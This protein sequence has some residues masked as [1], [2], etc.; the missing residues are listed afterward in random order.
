MSN[1]IDIKFKELREAGQ[2]AL[3]SFLT[4][5]F[6]DVKTSQELAQAILESGSDMLEL[7]IPFSDP[8]ADGRTI[9]KTNLHALEQ[10][11]NIATSLNM[12]RSLRSKGVA[13]PVIFMGYYN[14]FLRYGLNKFA[15][16]ASAAGLDGIIVPDLPSEEALP[17]KQAC[18]KGNIH[19]IPLLAPTSTDQRIA[20]ACEQA[21]GF[22]Y[23]VSLT[24][25]TGARKQL[26][27]GLE[28][29]VGRI[30]HHTDLPIAVGF[31]VSNP[32]HVDTISQFADGVIFASALLDTIDKSPRDQV[33][34]EATNFVS[35][36][37][38]ST[39]SRS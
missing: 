36:L 19:L 1:R 4:T 15:Q 3:I 14:P 13:S 18:N 27:P 34:Q 24:G 10:G 33:L 28:E 6:P 26:A 38:T 2:I 5:G 39:R 11:V 16:D 37:R 29:F 7:G 21:N 20:K 32:Q 12:L 35:S 8:L 25:V 23:C 30:R 22:I 9:Q 17:F 31:G